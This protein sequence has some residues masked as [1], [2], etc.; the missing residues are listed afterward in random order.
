MSDICRVTSVAD[1]GS[2]TQWSAIQLSSHIQ[3]LA[4]HCR[5]VT[6][7]F[8]GRGRPIVCEPVCSGLLE[9]VHC[10]GKQAL[11]LLKVVP[12]P[13]LFLL[14]YCVICVG[15]Y[16]LCAGRSLQQ[17]WSLHDIGHLPILVST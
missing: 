11:H 8:H 9:G 17:Y 12:P 7:I 1:T 15:M 2:W 10:A 14:L 5:A 6:A 4:A 13:A 3:S 16:Y